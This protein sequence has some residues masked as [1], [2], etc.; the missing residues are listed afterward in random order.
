M[1]KQSYAK[2]SQGWRKKGPTCAN[3]NFFTSDEKREVNSFGTYITDTNMRCIRGSF[4]TGKSAWCIFHVLSD[5][6]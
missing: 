1:S 3:C 2:D 4:K 6:E 5:D